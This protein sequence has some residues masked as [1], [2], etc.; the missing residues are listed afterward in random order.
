[1][2]VGDSSR[3]CEEIVKISNSAF[4]CDDDDDDDD[5]DDNDD[6]DYYYLKSLVAK[7]VEVRTMAQKDTLIQI[8]RYYSFILGFK[9]LTYQIKA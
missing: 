3:R 5:D 7:Q 1:M 8:T 9:I 2:C 6:D 4:E